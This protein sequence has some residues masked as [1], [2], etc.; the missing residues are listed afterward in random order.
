MSSDFFAR[1]IPMNPAIIS[2]IRITN[3]TQFVYKLTAIHAIAYTI[4][5]VATYVAVYIPTFRLCS[6]ICIFTEGYIAIEATKKLLYKFH[7]SP[8]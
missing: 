3:S 4:T 6:H 7:N 1:W 8:L 5:Y 2:R